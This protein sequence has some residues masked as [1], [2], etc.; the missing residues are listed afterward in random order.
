MHCITM[1]FLGMVDDAITFVKTHNSYICI[2]EEFED[3]FPDTLSKTLPPAIL[4]QIVCL[5][6]DK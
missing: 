6:W 1:L 4:F 2:S 3:S 5:G